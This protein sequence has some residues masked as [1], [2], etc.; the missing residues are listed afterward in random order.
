MAG[1]TITEANLTSALIEVPVTHVTAFRMLLR[2]FCREYD[3][4]IDHE[5]VENKQILNQIANDLTSPNVDISDVVGQFCGMYTI[6]DREQMAS[7]KEFFTSFANDWVELLLNTDKD[8]LIWDDEEL[9]D[10]ED[11]Q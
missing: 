3:L 1:L 4:E 7:I 9:E 2:P 11:D 10:I 6:N 5:C 8:Q